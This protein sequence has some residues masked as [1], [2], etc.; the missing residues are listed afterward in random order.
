[1]L[2]VAMALDRH[3]LATP[4]VGV[5][6]PVYNGEKFLRTA[7]DSALGQTYD[8]LQVIAVDDGST[9]SSPEIL[10][11]YGSRL[12]VVRQHNAGVAQA[13]NA[14]IQ[15]CQGELIAFLDQDDWWLPEKVEKQVARF[16]ADPALGLVH[17][18]ILQYS[19]SDG[20]F[21]DSIYPTDGSRRLRGHCYEQLLLGNSIFNSSVMIRR[22][23]LAASGMFNPT[24]VGN[25]VQDYDLWLRIAQHYPLDHVP[26]PLVALRL[27]G[28]QGTWDRR[29]ML[30]DE[31]DVL[32]RTVGLSGLRSSFAMRKRV[33][34]LLDELGV[35]YLDAQSPRLAQP[36]FARSLG[37]HW[38]VRAALI[39]T[40]CFLPC[41]GI[42]WLRRQL[43]RWRRRTSPSVRTR[44]QRSG[45]DPANSLA[46]TGQP[47]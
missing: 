5:V 33:A 15:A 13:R 47:N 16:R 42:E 11:S 43:K 39:W 35:A 18:G 34:Q 44:V 37:F 24:M 2:D 6:V 1:M 25:T 31:L 3:T 38:T 29:A 26:E 22:S 28:E 20:A 27:H 12:T 19:E 40:A 32:E 8:R 46:T 7:L 9:D 17:T 4:L 41:S 30:G 10:A 21:V 23:V 45:H 36:C 14:G